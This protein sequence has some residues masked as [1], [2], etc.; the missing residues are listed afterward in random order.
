MK[1]YY[2]ILRHKIGNRRRPVWI[3]NTQNIELWVHSAHLGDVDEHGEAGE[4]VHEQHVG[5]VRVHEVRLARHRRR[6]RERHG[7][8]VRRRGR[9]KVREEGA[10][11]GRERRDERLQHAEVQVRPV[12]CGHHAERSCQ[13]VQAE[14]EVPAVDE[15]ARQR[16]HAALHRHHQRHR[17]QEAARVHAPQ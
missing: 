14:P 3:T 16:E 4:R 8:R 11:R 15:R 1:T 10:Q 2:R 7:A 9:R 13:D 17:R 12:H 6:R 5:Q